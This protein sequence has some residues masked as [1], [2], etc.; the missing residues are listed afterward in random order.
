MTN[1]IAGFS[2]LIELRAH[3][4]STASTRPRPP[5]ARRARP[6][7]RRARGS[8]DLIG[9]PTSANATNANASADRARPD[10]SSSATLEPE[11]AADPGWR[12]EQMRP[13]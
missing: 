4:E 12:A 6:R 2:A 1:P 8:S 5:R 3:D 11:R 13:A 10:G 7:P 9:K